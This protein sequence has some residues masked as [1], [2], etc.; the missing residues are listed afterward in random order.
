MTAPTLDVILRT[1]PLIVAVFGMVFVFC[2]L[3]AYGIV[4]SGLGAVSTRSAGRL[5][6]RDTATVVLSPLD[7]LALSSAVS[8][9]Y[10][11][12]QDP[13]DR[14]HLD[15]LVVRGLMRRRSGPVKGDPRCG[16][17]WCITPK[18]AAVLQTYRSHHAA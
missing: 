12:P 17:Y 5:R 16:H 9:G 11:R 3:A 10:L 14:R 2:L 15:E 6:R 4:M 8:Y 13:V 18:G 1:L 7:Q